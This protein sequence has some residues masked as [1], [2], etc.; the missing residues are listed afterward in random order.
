MKKVKSKSSAHS[1]P[2]SSRLSTRG[3]PWNSLFDCIILEIFYTMQ[4]NK[5]TYMFI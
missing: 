1:W 3:N 4:A 2:K 5:C